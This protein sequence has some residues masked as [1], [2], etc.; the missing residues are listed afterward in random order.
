MESTPNRVPLTPFG[1]QTNIYHDRFEGLYS[2]PDG[3][4]VMIASRSWCD[5]RRPHTCNLEMKD[6]L[7]S[8]S[9][10]GIEIEICRLWIWVC[11]NTQPHR[12]VL[13]APGYPF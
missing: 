13:K 1:G 6:V 8:F 7:F 12:D 3:T 5:A 11:G 2:V 4:I 9:D 10:C